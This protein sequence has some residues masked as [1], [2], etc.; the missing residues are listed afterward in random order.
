MEKRLTIIV[1]ASYIPSHPSIHIMQEVIESF[2]FI[3]LENYDVILAHDFDETEDYKKYLIALENYVSQLPNH[4]QFKIIIKPTWGCLTGNIRYSIEKGNVGTD[5]ILV[6]QHDMPFVREF[7]IENI[8]DDMDKNPQLKHIRFNVHTTKTNYWDSRNEL[9]GAELI[10]NN[11]TYVRTP[12]WSD[13]N[14]LCSLKYYKD[15]VLSECKDGSYMEKTLQKKCTDELTHAKYGTYIFGK[16]GDK[17]YS[18]HTHGRMWNG[19]L[20]SRIKHSH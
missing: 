16:M 2:R 6:M 8:M 3:S 17:S 10:C 1:T 9:F 7:N 11:Y 20:A 5:Y 19:Q 18:K 12:S 13:N 14:H 15:I 4:K